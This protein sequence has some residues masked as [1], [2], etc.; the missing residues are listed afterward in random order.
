MTTSWANRRRILMRGGVLHAPG[1][2]GATA[3]LVDGDVIAWLGD[4]AAADV[5]ADAADEIWRLDGRLVTPGFVDAH[6]HATSTGLTLT[7]L[8]LSTTNSVAQALDAVADAAGRMTSAVVLGHG[9]DETRW[10]EHRPPTADELDRAASGAAVYLSRVDVHSAAVS[11]ALMRQVSELHSLDGYS[12]DGWLTRDAHHRVRKVAFGSVGP[13]QRHAAQQ[14][15]RMRAA[16][17]GIVAVQEMGGP[18]IS[19]E[20]DF[21]ALLASSAEHPGPL[22]VGYW[23]ELAQVGGVE[24]AH[25]L[26]AL[27][28]G[29]D[30]FVDG[31]IGSHTACLRHAYSDAPGDHGAQYLDGDTIAEHVRA[32][33]D[34]GLQAG[35]HVIGD[36]AIDAV[37]GAIER[38]A[39][40]RGDDVVRLAAIRL[41]H[42]E[43]LDD[44]HITTMARLGVTASMQP[45][46]DALWGGEHGMYATRLGRDR[47]ARM[48]RH[49]H[50]ARAGVALAFGS[51]APV[52][53]LGPWAA[54]RAAVLHHDVEQ[55]IS[56]RAAFN[57]HTRG[58][59]RAIGQPQAGV[60][61]PG[62]PAHLAI[63]NVSDVVVQVQDDRVRNWSTD[64]RSATPGLPALG[65]DVP[66]PTAARTIVAGSTVFDDG[67]IDA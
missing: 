18:V 42:A 66:L 2:P 22:A 19:S 65:E 53:S 67:S 6:V 54:V 8:D 13:N 39:T 37:L 56:A 20:E 33:I 7:S 48:N 31:A 64:P 41:E 40:D 4:D 17:L 9:W 28:A 59:W 34:A 10:P 27:G 21:T 14:T 47:A 35:F 44:S 12:A 23:G 3:M 16:Q 38:V 30:L 61:A 55:R 36:A 52:T 1:N 24:R 11:S 51:D 45:M 46:F 57:A 60:I 32:C 5:Y 43:M 50:L 15:A 29:G 58:G 63:W 62:A 26:G 49:A 25:R